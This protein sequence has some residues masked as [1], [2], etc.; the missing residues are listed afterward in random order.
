MERTSILKPGDVIG[1]YRV[2]RCLG[3]G[4]MGEVHLV[5]HLQLHVERALKLL[6]L[7]K[8]VRNS[9]FAERFLREARIA[10]RIQ[11][12]NVISVFDVENDVNSGFLYIVM[13]YVKGNSLQGILQNGSLE[14]DQAVHIISEVVNGLS[15]AEEMGLVHRDIKPSN[16]M[17][18]Q[19]GEVKL[20]D[21][22]IAKAI[23]DDVGVTLTMENS[24]VGTP[25]YCSPEQCRNAHN[26]DVRADIYSLGATLYEMV[27]GLPP[28]DGVNSFD[29]IAHVL[30]D[31]PTKPRRLNPSLSAGL[32]T[33]ILKMMSKDPADRPQNIT[34]LK[35]ELKPFQSWNMA[36]PPELKSL[37]RDRV[38]REVLD[39]TSTVIASYR[40]KQ[41][42]ERIVWSGVAL[43]LLI[44]FI[45]VIVFQQVHYGKEIR[46]WKET[47]VSHQNARDV[48][49][50]QI[51]S[52]K[53]QLE[54]KQKDYLAY[55]NRL[56]S[57]IRRLEAGPQRKAPETPEGTDQQ[58][59]PKQPEASAASPA[60]PVP[61]GE[62]QDD[63]RTAADNPESQVPKPGAASPE[64]PSS[65]TA[66]S[67]K[68]GVPTVK[69]V[70]NEAVQ[71]IDPNTRSKKTSEAF[72]KVSRIRRNRAD[73]EAIQRAVNELDPEKL[74]RLLKKYEMAFEELNWISTSTLFAPL[75]D[76]IRPAIFYKLDSPGREREKIQ[77]YLADCKRRGYKPHSYLLSRSA[78]QPGKLSKEQQQRYEQNFLDVSEFL[79]VNPDFLLDPYIFHNG[80][81]PSL[82]Q[83]RII[84][85]AY[86]FNDFPQWLMKMADK[87]YLDFKS[88]NSLLDR[89][90]LYFNT[91]RP[92][93]PEQVRCIEHLIR[94]GARY[95]RLQKEE[96][97]LIAAVLSDDP[98]SVKLA[99][100]KCRPE[101][102]M[103]P[104][105]V[106]GNILGFAVKGMGKCNPEI[107]RQLI[108]SKVPVNL[109]AGPGWIPPSLSL[110]ASA[111]DND[112]EAVIELLIRHG[113]RL[114]DRAALGAACRRNNVRMAERLL[115]NGTPPGGETFRRIAG[116]TSRVFIPDRLCIALEN[117]AVDVAKLLLQ[118]D[119]DLRVRMLPSRKT[120][121]EIAEQDPDLKPV[122]DLIRKKLGQKAG[123][124]PGAMFSN[125]HASNAG[126][127][128]LIRQSEQVPETRK[129]KKPSSREWFVHFGR[130]H[131]AAAKSGKKIL[132][133]NHVEVPPFLLSRRNL[134]SFGQHFVLLFCPI[135][136]RQPD[137]PKDQLQHIGD[138]RRGLQLMNGYPETVILNPDGTR[139][140]RFAGFPFHT[141]R[142]FMQIADRIKNGEVPDLSAMQKNEPAKRKRSSR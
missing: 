57:Q 24:L 9:V 137:Y 47:A 12:K 135:S 33:L 22:G 51:A 119:I 56:E 8:G 141:E 5:T 69:P 138:I 68:T 71:M 32:E 35:K 102:L 140:F 15:A 74:D 10:S 103:K 65:Q 21:M 130:A 83:I 91:K 104:Y 115:K 63:R 126:F 96:R 116:K 43:A 34:E 129:W 45:V 136:P 41:F 98:E 60:A 48:L 124:V 92:A 142:S 123:S 114:K 86:D 84:S 78:N 85:N 134:Q 42:G 107:V 62:K 18:S 54:R 72:K 77:V 117:K 128:N 49:A 122:A 23:G 79:L 125:P 109:Y 131:S 40:R 76:L 75:N 127:Q 20:A 39:R 67:A 139:F 31:E 28:F 95:D 46:Y 82:A 14:E 106:Y 121:L 36:I 3:I 100:R 7:D 2:V 110:L 81:S 88:D 61:A 17:I 90:F 93:S 101:N 97:D 27:T 4:G 59:A 133:L 58:P 120:P 73:L 19:D 52:M 29:T 38:E 70:Q 53:N 50:G 118:Y 99:I 94:A 66:A 30:S 89:L 55:T 132:V 37:F 113:V 13:E 11:H 1:K 44:I 80:G 112:D 25:A 111:I 26:V 87:Q 16:I 6:R 105:P 108:E 64:T